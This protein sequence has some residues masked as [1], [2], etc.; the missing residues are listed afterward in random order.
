MPT[1]FRTGLVLALL[2]ASTF[3]ATPLSAEEKA[4]GRFAVNEQEYFEAPGVT[5]Q[6]FHDIYPEGHQGGLSIIQHGERVARTA[7]STSSP[8]PDSGHR[9]RRLVRGPPIRGRGA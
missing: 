5:V 9:S 6:V 4:P 2:S 1:R 7:T 3:S 8:C